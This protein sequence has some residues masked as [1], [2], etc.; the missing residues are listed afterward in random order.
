MDVSPL[1]LVQAF[2]VGIIAPIYGLWGG[3]KPRKLLTSQPD[4]WIS[5]YRA[6][7]LTQIA[8]VGLTVLIFMLNRD[9]MEIIG[10]AFGGQDAT[11]S[12]DRFG[13]LQASGG[14]S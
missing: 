9:S 14:Q 3:P 7:S 6:T 8:L 5:V 13:N 1:Y 12:A 4:M 11:G 2:I 10:L